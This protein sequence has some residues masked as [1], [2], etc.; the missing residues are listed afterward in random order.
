MKRMNY[1]R[2]LAEVIDVKVEDI[3][4]TSVFTT[5]LDDSKQGLA[6]ADGDLDASVNA[7]GA[8]ILN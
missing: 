4:T 2:P 8:I 3:I 7:G 6:L 5:T 1:V